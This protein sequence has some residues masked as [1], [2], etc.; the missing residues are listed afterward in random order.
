MGLNTLKAKGAA[1]IKTPEPEDFA[2]T[3]AAMGLR[4]VE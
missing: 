4:R 1:P 2:I 3:A